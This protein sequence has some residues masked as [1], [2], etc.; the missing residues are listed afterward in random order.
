MLQASINGLILGCAYALAALGFVLLYENTGFIN[1]AQGDFVTLGSFLAYQAA[2]TWQLPWY[3]VI[4]VVVGLMAVVGLVTER[5]VRPLVRRRALFISVIAS[6]G[7]G[8]CIRAFIQ[9]HWGTVPLSVPPLIGGKS[10][11]FLGT[12]VD[13][14]SLL[15]VVVAAV[16]ITAMA[17]VYERTFLGTKIRAAATDPEVA[18]LM[19]VRVGR[20]MQASFAASAVMAGV[21]GMLLVPEYLATP[22]FGYSI[23]FLAIIAIFLGGFGSM[24]GAVVGALVIGLVQL[25]VAYEVSSVGIQNAVLYAILLAVLVLRPRGIFGKPLQEKV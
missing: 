10:V 5:I 19:G 12:A 23:L 7:I 2:V 13:R 8:L 4:V 3:G 17:L 9:I 25:D 6:L 16:L 18:R 21:A 11:H 24:I 1:F 22:T 14:Q 20:I 15:I